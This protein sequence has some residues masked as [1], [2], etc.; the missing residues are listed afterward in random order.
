MSLV[1]YGKECPKRENC[2][3]YK[4]RNMDGDGVWHVDEKSQCKYGKDSFLYVKIKED[5]GK[6]K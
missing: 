5:D 1:C 3:R 4:F 2:L 6:S